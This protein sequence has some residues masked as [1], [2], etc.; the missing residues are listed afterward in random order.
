MSSAGQVRL[1][2]LCVALRF[3][4]RHLVV[5]LEVAVIEETGVVEELEA[6][7]PSQKT[8]HFEKTLLWLVDY[9]AKGS[10]GTVEV[11]V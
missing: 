9:H 3:S 1:A 11:A 10:R 2:P 7:W 5:S 8:R 6:V 4:S